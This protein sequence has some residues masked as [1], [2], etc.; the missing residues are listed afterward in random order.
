MRYLGKKL[1]F[2]NKS[3]QLIF[4]SVQDME[5][6]AKAMLEWVDEDVLPVKYGG[7]NA[8]P[9]DQWPLEVEMRTYVDNLTAGKK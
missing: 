7:K 5:A 4:V 6:A 2:I 3:F 9:M 1:A 8:L